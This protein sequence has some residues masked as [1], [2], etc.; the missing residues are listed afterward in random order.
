MASIFYLL[1]YYFIYFIYYNSAISRSRDKKYYVLDIYIYIYIKVR[2]NN[3]CVSQYFFLLSLITIRSLLHETSILLKR[4]LFF[5]FF[6]FY[7][8]FFFFFNNRQ[9]TRI[10]FTTDY[11]PADKRSILISYAGNAG[12]FFFFPSLEPRDRSQVVNVANRI[13]Q[14]DGGRDQ[15]GRNVDQLPRLSRRFHDFGPPR[16]SPPS[17]SQRRVHAS[18]FRLIRGR[19]GQ[20]G[21]SQRDPIGAVQ[22][23]ASRQIILPPVFSQYPV[24]QSPLQN[25]LHLQLSIHRLRSSKFSK[26]NPIKIVLR[27]NIYI[28][29][30]YITL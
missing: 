18:R 25:C 15:R 26:L 22:L 6:F 20:F 1:L 17:A 16:I 10:F 2:Y 5:F 4:T 12:S 9:R 21:E 11:S 30:I 7:D 23:V 14:A 3:F 13:G 19:Q 27:L 24:F 29:Y 8:H 28:I